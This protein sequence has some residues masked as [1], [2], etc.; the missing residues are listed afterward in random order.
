MRAHVQSCL[1]MEA[2]GLLAGTGDLIQEVLPITNQEQSPTRFRM[3]ARE[4]LSA[5]R[6]MEQRGL[7]LVGIFH[8]HPAE[9]NVGTRPSGVP[10]PTDIEEAAYPVVNVIWSPHEG[11]WR[12]SGFWIEDGSFAEVP[13]HLTAEK[14]PTTEGR[15]THV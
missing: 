12:A 8:S 7:E 9:S 13:L 3:D 1:P 10:S 5:F 15:V 14:Q 4:Q 2:C 11:E 6:F